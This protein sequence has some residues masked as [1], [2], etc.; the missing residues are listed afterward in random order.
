M[1][2]TKLENRAI[3]ITRHYDGEH[4]GPQRFDCII[5]A[6]KKAVNFKLYNRISNQYQFS[7]RSGRGRGGHTGN[8]LQHIDDVD[9]DVDG[10]CNDSESDNEVILHQEHKLSDRQDWGS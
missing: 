10:S 9:A 4:I 1:L 3:F 6:A 2:E 5:D 7:W 8:R